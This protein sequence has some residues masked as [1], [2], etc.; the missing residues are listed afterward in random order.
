[1]QCTYCYGKRKNYKEMSMELFAALEK[2]L[3]KHCCEVNLFLSGE[4]TLS[5]NF[6]RMLRRCAAYP[7]ITK[8]FTN[9]SYRNDALLRELVECGTWVNISFDGMKHSAQT[10]KGLNLDFFL[11]NIERVQELQNQIQN[12]KFH[13]R[14][15]VVVSKLNV[16][17]LPE[18]VRWA[19]KM[20]FKELMLGCLDAI[21]NKRKNMVTSEDK[22]YFE[23]AVRLSDKLKIRISTPS[24]IAGARI[25]KS[26]NWND[27][28]LPIDRYFP[29]FIEDCNPDVRKKF[30]PY[31]WLQT[32][33]N[34]NGEV[35]SCCQRKI[36]IGKMDP[37]KDFINDLWN[38][39]LY[40]T[41]RSFGDSRKC[42]FFTD[43][44]CMLMENSIWG[45]ECRLDN[46]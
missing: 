7:F 11:R 15:A 6:T 43:H 4:P 35:M 46:L 24:H 40:Q 14:L 32:V 34:A 2:Q 28:E 42:Y 8:I 12:P 3:F 39:K 21:H 26:N 17:E 41:L 29:H 10:R 36:V 37:D 16:A 23:E 1:M 18:I 45:G 44:E 5:G 13:L 19:V 25:E 22:V 27:F 20:R 33:I 31:P 38:N 30:C 9:F